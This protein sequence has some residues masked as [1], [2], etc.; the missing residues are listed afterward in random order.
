MKY[1][2]KYSR[3]LIA[4]VRKVA[5]DDTLLQEFFLDLLTPKEYRELALR[6][7]IVKQLSQKISQ[8]EIVKHLGVSIATITRGSRELLDSEGG[9]RKVLR[10]YYAHKERK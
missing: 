1:N 3:E 8:R 7:Q 4:L 9:F 5:T 10:K 2:P 6:W